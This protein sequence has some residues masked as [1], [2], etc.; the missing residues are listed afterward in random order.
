MAAI[1]SHMHN[2]RVMWLKTAAK[3]S[4]IPD[5]L[6]KEKVTPSQARKALEESREALANV[7]QVCA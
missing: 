2:V 5:Q 3:D 4:K 7:L 6:V 1:V